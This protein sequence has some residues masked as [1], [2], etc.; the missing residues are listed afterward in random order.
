MFTSLCFHL[1]VVTKRIFDDSDTCVFAKND[2]DTCM[3]I[4]A[5]PAIFHA[6]VRG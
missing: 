6:L 1:G 3:L 4:K 5:G 2:S